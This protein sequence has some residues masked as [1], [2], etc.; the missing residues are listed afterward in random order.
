MSAMDNVNR[1]WLVRTGTLSAGVLLIAA[2]LVIVNYFG[3]KYHKR[4]DWTSSR[5]YTLSEKSENV[6]EGLMRDVDF[7]VFLPPND[8]LYEPVQELLSQY[9]AA[10]QRLRVRYVDPQK[11][12]L[13]AERL[14][15][16]YQISGYGVVVASGK[17]R[18]V[19]PSA[20]LAEMDFSGMQFGQAPTVSGFKGEQVF[21]GAILQL[22]EGKK[23][24]VLFTTGHGERSLDDQGPE[25]LSGIQDILGADNFDSEE[26]SALGK[27]AIPP[28][29]DLVVVA[30]PKSPFLQPELDALAAYLDGGGR[31]LVLLEPNL[32]QAEGTG[33]TA[34]GF[35]TWLPRFGVKLGTNIV[36]DPPNTIPGFTAAT[37]F[38][39]DY[40]DHPVTKA[41]MQSKLPVLLSVIRSVARGDAAG[42]KATELM[43]SS[44]E[45]WGETNLAALAE[46]ER[47]EGDV[48]GPVPLGVAVQGE[49]GSGG[50]AKMRLAVFGDSDFA[51][52]QLIQANPPNRVLLA[53]ALNWLV[54]RE[55]LLAIPPRKTEQVRLNLTKEQGLTVYGVAL[56][57]MPVLAG[58]AGITVWSRRRR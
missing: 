42:F 34:T 52:N 55:A 27:T 48:E 10:S 41:L 17:D 2:L 56:A 16:Q 40:G 14:I 53:N 36:V 47:G 50:K 7:I 54:E 12:R 5:L 21:T 15:R 58:I 37:L 33:L 25:G 39:N 51:T 45:G 6:V 30:G 11:D 46:V 32:G 38:V 3:W 26:W 35:E 8:E 28:G 31:L 57:L 43:R 22:N 4:F 19:I 49:G 44:S 24:K 13:E 23:P 29:S 20:D 9:D 1:R 18:R